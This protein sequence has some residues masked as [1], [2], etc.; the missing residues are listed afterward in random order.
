MLRFHALFLSETGRIRFR[1]NEGV[2]GAGVY[3][4]L[5]CTNLVFSF[6]ERENGKESPPPKQ[7]FSILAEPLKSLESRKRAE[8]GFGEYGFKHRAQ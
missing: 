2:R 3:L 5:P 1:G 8:Y 7:G 6:F 4:F